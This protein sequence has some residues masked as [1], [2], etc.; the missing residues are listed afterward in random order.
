MAQQPTVEINVEPPLIAEEIVPEAPV[1]PEIVEAPV[2]EVLSEPSEVV[3]IVDAVVTENLGEEPGSILEEEPL[4]EPITEVVTQ[5]EDEPEV[6]EDS[7][8]PFQVTATDEVQQVVE[9]WL[10]AWQQQDLNAYFSSYH[11]NFEP[12]SFSSLTTWQNNRERNILRPASIDIDY[13]D[14]MVL[15]RNADS[16]M[17]TLRMT[18]ES[19]TYAD[20][21]L[22]QL[23]LVR[24]DQGDWKIIFEENI[25][26]ERLPVN[27]NHIA[28]NQAVDRLDVYLVP[29]VI[30]QGV[31][32]GSVV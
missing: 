18:Y 5:I 32:V 22:K 27:R 24:D 20:S 10:Q 2:A 17:L 3:E 30:S 15:S 6:V 8:T 4:S 14:Y 26:V 12:I 28:E 23:G 29:A 16:T 7:A 31:P 13:D 25:Q 21:S 19:P 1:I 11:E 9:Q